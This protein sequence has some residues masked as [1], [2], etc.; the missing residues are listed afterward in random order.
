MKAMKKMQVSQH[1]ERVRSRSHMVYRRVFLTYGY[2]PPSK[3]L[4][5][6]DKTSLFVAIPRH[7]AVHA[8]KETPSAKRTLLTALL[9][10]GTVCV[11]VRLTFDAVD[12]RLV[13]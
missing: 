13:M 9:P 3:Q 7:A 1:K 10:I 12:M 2:R 5:A 6:Q 8:H 11:D 4:E